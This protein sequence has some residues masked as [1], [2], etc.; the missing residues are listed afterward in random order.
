MHVKQKSDTRPGQG[1][2]S[3]SK[4]EL[5]KDK[6]HLLRV[7]FLTLHRLEVVVSRQDVQTEVERW[8]MGQQMILTGVAVSPSHH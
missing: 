6:G 3:S 4:A 5:T 1:W 2:S 8:P 7:S